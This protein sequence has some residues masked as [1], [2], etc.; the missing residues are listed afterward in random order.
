MLLFTFPNLSALSPQIS[1]SVPSVICKFSNSLITPFPP[2]Y[3]FSPGFIFL[4]AQI[5]FHCASRITLLQVIIVLFIFSPF[6]L[7]FWGKT[8]TLGKHCCMSSSCLYLGKLN[9]TGGKKIT[10]LILHYKLVISILTLAPNIYPNFNCVSLIG[11][12]LYFIRSM[13][14]FKSPKPI[15]YSHIE[16]KTLP[17][18]F[19]KE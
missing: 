17:Q 3:P 19:C 13:Y 2:I 14:L 5:K 12:F 8:Q 11:S 18:T 7:F 6:I 9:I 16:L 4:L 10:W 1:S 15:F